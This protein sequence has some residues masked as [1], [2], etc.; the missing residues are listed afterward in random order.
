MP[1][2]ALMIIIFMMFL[3]KNVLDH[4]YY[5]LRNSTITFQ[6]MKLIGAHVSS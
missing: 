4:L 3:R 2:V 6:V 1:K 5:K